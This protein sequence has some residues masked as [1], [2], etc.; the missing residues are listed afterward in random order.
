M[1]YVL[2]NLFKCTLKST[3]CT[4]D[5]IGKHDLTFSKNQKRLLCTCIFCLSTS[6]SSRVHT[7][8]KVRR[9]SQS[10]FFSKWSS[11]RHSYKFCD[12]IYRVVYVREMIASEA[13]CHILRSFQISIGSTNTRI[14]SFLAKNIRSE[15]SHLIWANFGSD[16]MRSSQIW[17][18]LFPSEHLK[19]GAYFTRSAR[20]TCSC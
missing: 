5:N 13:F 11:S 10:Y 7:F 20:P 3:R 4:L 1:Y 6:I 14:G 12:V 18:F 2:S 8:P 15:A 9:G 16:Q 19:F 17:C